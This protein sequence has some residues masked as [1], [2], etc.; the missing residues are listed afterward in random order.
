[1]KK[2]IITIIV[3]LIIMISTRTTAVFAGSIPE[4]LLYYDKAQVFFGELVSV[5]ADDETVTVLPT[6]KI[7]GDVDIGAEQ[8]YQKD[9]VALGRFIPKVGDI[10]LMG[11]YNDHNPLYLFRTTSTDQR[12]LTITNN[13]GSGMEERM[14]EYLNNGD[15][16]KAEY[17]RLVKLGSAPLPV[18]AD[19]IILHNQNN[20]TNNN[21]FIIISIVSFFA[22][23]FVLVLILGKRKY[24]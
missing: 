19:T 1:M 3:I 9:V 18:L 7:K 20:E 11:H 17:K 24:L 14:Q 23:C 6:Q 2:R 4:D 10:Y 16:E 21:L 22:V 5:S 12:T 8:K 15:F 13:T